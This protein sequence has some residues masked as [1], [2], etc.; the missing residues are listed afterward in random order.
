MIVIVIVIIV[1]III[2]H[3][4]IL[5][6]ASFGYRAHSAPPAVAPVRSRQ[7]VW[8]DRDPLLSYTLAVEYVANTLLVELFNPSICFPEEAFKEFE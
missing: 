3:I 1:A 5:P 2:V 4:I 7:S 6:A 8:Q